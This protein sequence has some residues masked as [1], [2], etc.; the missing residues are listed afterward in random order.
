MIPFSYLGYSRIDSVIAKRELRHACCWVGILQHRF[1]HDRHA[2]ARYTEDAFV[3]V[4]ETLV[5][6]TMEIEYVLRGTYCQHL[7]N[8]PEGWKGNCLDVFVPR[9]RTP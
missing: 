1:S 5:H 9:T 2:L 8:G 4:L 3:L 7:I 6:T